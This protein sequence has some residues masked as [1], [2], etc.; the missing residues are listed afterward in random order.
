LIIR[1]ASDQAPG[2]SP[3]SPV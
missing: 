3:P 2:K 1:A